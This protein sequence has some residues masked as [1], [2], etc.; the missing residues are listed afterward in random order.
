MSLAFLKTD[1]SVMAL[2]KF[3]NTFLLSPDDFPPPRPSCSL[4][5]HKSHLY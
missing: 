1:G 2:V 3:Q 5:A 4:D